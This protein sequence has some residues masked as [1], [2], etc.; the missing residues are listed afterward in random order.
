MVRRDGAAAEPLT[1][2]PPGLKVRF[3]ERP[4]VAGPT[5]K[6]NVGWRATAAPLVAFTDDDCRAHPSW[7]ESLLA[8]A[9]GGGT[10]M[11]GRTEPD[12][13]ERHLL[14]G[15]AR[16]Q[17]IRGPGGRGGNRHKGHPR[18]LPG[19]FGRLHR[20]PAVRGGGTGLPV[21]AF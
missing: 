10:F 15:F 4:G 20:V 18:E 21:P 14:H 12:P 16:S 7:L 2:A 17:E 5:A 19:R 13:D 3:L 1:Q 11:Q 9:N 8:A 6:R